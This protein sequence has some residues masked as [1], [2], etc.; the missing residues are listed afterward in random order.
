MLLSLDTI[1]FIDVLSVTSSIIYNNT[2]KLEMININS[3][4]RF[5]LSNKARRQ[6]IKQSLDYVV[7]DGKLYTLEGE[8][9]GDQFQHDILTPIK[10][11]KYYDKYLNNEIERHS[12]VNGGFIF[13]L[14]KINNDI[15]ETTPSLS[16]SDIAR[17]IYLATYTSYDTGQ[18]KKGDGTIITSQDIHILLKFTKQRAKTFIDK[19]VSENVIEIDKDG[20]IFMNPSLFYKGKLRNIIKVVPE[21]NY[22]RLFKN[23]VRDIFEKAEPRE[24]VHLA[25]I[26][27]TLPYINLYSNI[28]SYNPDEKDHNLIKPMELSELAKKL[29]YSSRDKFTNT[30]NKL[31][32]DGQPVFNYFTDVKDKRKRNIVVNPR[33]V[34]SGNSEQLE[35]V[36]VM[37]NTSQ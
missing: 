15:R 35:V 36:R 12:D 10:D 22:T 33:V 34:F 9:I 16:K 2:I 17:L 21:S 37:F 18:L 29:G 19:L 8:Y 5:N 11:N 25:T 27:M 4:D 14:Y 26:Y 24:I 7:K 32:V 31:K 30:L 13:V 1:E 20:F 28:I 23:T 3:L 6:V